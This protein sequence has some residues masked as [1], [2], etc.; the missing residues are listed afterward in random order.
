ME[1]LSL[2]LL[3]VITLPL[4][5][6]AAMPPTTAR[7]MAAT[8]HAPG[9]FSP[10]SAD[11]SSTT[12]VTKQPS[13]SAQAAPSSSEDVV[14]T[15]PEAYRTI[16][17]EID[18]IIRE[19]INPD[20]PATAISG[21]SP[22]NYK[23][24]SLEKL[25]TLA[26]SYFLPKVR[27]LRAQRQEAFVLDT[28]AT[29]LSQQAALLTDQADRSEQ[30][31]LTA[32]ATELTEKAAAIKR[33]VPEEKILY[34]FFRSLGA[35]VQAKH[36]KTIVED[37]NC[38]HK[39]ATTYLDTQLARMGL[40]DS[41]RK[42]VKLLLTREFADV[43]SLPVSRIDAFAKE[44][45]L[46]LKKVATAYQASGESSTGKEFLDIFFYD[47]TQEDQRNV[48]V[49]VLDAHQLMTH[50]RTS[51]T[52]LQSIKKEKPSE[53]ASLADYG[54]AFF[55]RA[56]TKIHNPLEAL[57]AIE[58]AKFPKGK[59]PIIVDQQVFRLHDK[60]QEL[61]SAVDSIVKD[62]SLTETRLKELQAQKYPKK[63]ERTGLETTLQTQQKEKDKLDAHLK[64]VTLL[65]GIQKAA[66]SSL[67][68]AYPEI[69]GAKVPNQS[70]ARAVASALWSL[71]PSA[72]TLTSA[73]ETTP[74]TPATIWL[75]TVEQFAD[76]LVAD[77]NAAHAAKLSQLEEYVL[78]Y[79]G[80]DK[81]KKK[82][83]AGYPRST[84]E[85]AF[86][87]KFINDFMETYQELVRS[88]DRVMKQLLSAADYHM[89]KSLQPTPPAA[90]D[91]SESVEINEASSH[92][93]PLTALATSSSQDA[94]A[95]PIS[96]T[97]LSSAA[98]TSLPIPT[99]PANGSK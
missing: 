25:Q 98:T 26:V 33:T 15:S 70:A 12:I 9:V 58:G 8:H 54:T 44:T 52:T 83:N 57:Y 73:I 46:S 50:R 81:L 71:L 82:I 43:E 7:R 41:L 76:T 95:A 45:A 90:S 20:T 38:T 17:G 39:D 62:I 67:R 64:R 18:A 30:E 69:E 36:P 19:K 79:T 5:L 21:F 51:S 85:V 3:A 11:V 55:E 16:F 94:S 87:E 47:P 6:E 86:P 27:S 22:H 35:L 60:K 78:S 88:K 2:F 93:D 28:Q 24:F 92:S 99:V 97:V 72:P 68:N 91:L 1:N 48:Q 66:G 10:A 74:R 84:E 42:E 65:R 32:L 56:I 49:N 75:E 29:V 96:E 77:E 89:W 34:G 14:I 40:P 80:S 61:Q 23:T 53:L 4:Q 37:H 63:E 13:A 31:R 59:D